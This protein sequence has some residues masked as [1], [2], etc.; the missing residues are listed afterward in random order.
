MELFNIMR[1][2]AIKEQNNSEFVKDRIIE[3]PV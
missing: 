3:V 1:E 2:K